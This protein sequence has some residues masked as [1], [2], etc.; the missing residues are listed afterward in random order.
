MESVKGGK[1][2]MMNTILR[3]GSFVP[4]ILSLIGLARNIFKAHKQHS[5]N[6]SELVWIIILVIV[7]ILQVI[8]VWNIDY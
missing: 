6:K 8:L 3:I 1:K 4:L 2:Y 5:Y 7:M